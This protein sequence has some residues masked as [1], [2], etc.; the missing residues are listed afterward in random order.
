MTALKIAGCIVMIL[1]ISLH[2][3][4]LVSRVKGCRESRSM[5]FLVLLA[6]T[7]ATATCAGSVLWLLDRGPWTLATGVVTFY[8]AER[9]AARLAPEPPD[10]S[11]KPS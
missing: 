2:F 11:A 4:G 1:T 10:E 6:G 8:G 3:A 7:G 9:A 5:R